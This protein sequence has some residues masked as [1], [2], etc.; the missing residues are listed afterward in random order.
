MA[1]ASWLSLSTQ[2]GSGNANVT[3]GATSDNTDST[4]YK[5]WKQI[6]VF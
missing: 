6:T 4:T 3:A 2:S 1:L 5:A